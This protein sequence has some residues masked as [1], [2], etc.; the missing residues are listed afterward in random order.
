MQSR[1]NNNTGNL[2]PR[3]RIW[4]G[5]AQVQQSQQ[6]IEHSVVV[7]GFSPFSYPFPGTLPSAAIGGPVTPAPMASTAPVLPVATPART[8]PAAPNSSAATPAPM[9]GS[10]S[11]SKRA[12]RHRR[13]NAALASPISRTPSLSTPTPTPTTATSH[14]SPIRQDAP[15]CNMLE[16][17]PPY[18][19]AEWEE[20]SVV[21]E[22]EPH[23]RP[24]VHMFAPE[25]RGLIKSA[26]LE[27]VVYMSTV[28]GFPQVKAVFDAA[29][30]D[31]VA[32]QHYNGGGKKI[33]LSDNVMRIV[34][35]V[36]PACVPYI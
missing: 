2:G 3:Q 4:A 28:D 32:R 20:P 13:R 14:S 21:K 19:D 9:S 5:M 15:H 1:S 31:I 27:L 10:M 36:V 7:P 24:Y 17:R 18:D 22:L 12:P 16:N 23:Q 33:K 30:W 8:T 26:N 25:P 35:F 29:V 6:P 11:S 34:S